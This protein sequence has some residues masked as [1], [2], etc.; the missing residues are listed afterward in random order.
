MLGSIAEKSLR[1]RLMTLVFFAMLAVGGFYYIPLI[2]IDAVPD[3]TSVQVVV[4]TKTGALDPEQIEKTVTY[5][6]E[7]EMSGI[8]GVDEVRSLSKYGLS[9]VV[10]IFKD[11]TNIY[12]ARQQVSERL[13]AV[14]ESLPQGAGPELAPITT[15]L[16]EVLMYVVLP[17]PGS[18]LASAEEKER[19]LYLRTIQDFV[20]RPYLRAHVPNVAEVDSNGGF[21]KEIHIEVD[22][23][24][25]EERGLSIEDLV[26]KLE[27]LGESFGGGYIQHEGKQ[28][29]VRA[30]GSL[31]DLDQIRRITVKLDVRGKPIRLGEVTQIRQDHAQRLGAATYDGNEAVLGTVLMLSGANSRQVAL[32]AE[33][34]LKEMEL[35]P[36]VAIKILYSRRFLVEAVIKTVAKNLAEGA[37]LVVIVLLLLLG[38]LRAALI[39][40]LAIPLSMLVAAMGMK[41]LGISAN[42]MSLGAIDFGLL[43]DASVVIIENV[44]R[45]LR[46]KQGNLSLA[47]KSHLVIESCREVVIPVTLGLLLIMAAYVP[48]LALE[49]IEGKIFRPMAQTVLMAL[50]ASLLVALFLMPVLAYLFLR[51]GQGGAGETRLFAFIQKYYEPLL[52]WSFH[53]PTTVLGPVIVIAF[54]TLFAYKRLGAD[55]MPAL[56]EGDMVINLTREAS[57]GPDESVRIQ[58]E[59]DKVIASFGEVKHVFSRL[60][61]AESATDPMGI[62]LSDTF[63]ILEKVGNKWPVSSG[64]K[65]KTKEELFEAIRKT[66][67]EKTPGQEIMQSQPIEMRLNEI[68]EGSR[69][70]VSVRIYGKDLE[71]LMDLLDKSKALLQEIPGASEV[72]LDALTALRRS[73]VI[74]VRLDYEKIARLGVDIQWVN[75]LLETAMGGREVG[76]FYEQ[77][78]RFPIVVRLTE[79]L[80]DNPKELANL[81]VGLPEKGTAPLSALATLENKDQVTTIAHEGGQR[82]AAVSVN[83][84]AS[85]TEGFVREAKRVLS[86]ELSLP[87]GYRLSWGGQFKNLERAQAKLKVI[88]PLTLLAIFLALL[89][90]FERNWRQALIVYLG[91]PFAVTGGVFS[92]YLRDI[93]LSVSAAVGFIALSGIAILNAMV[94]VTFFN[95]LRKQGFSLRESVL[96]GSLIRLRPV[97][98]TALVASLGFLPMALNT[99]IG[100]EVQRPLAT[101]VIGGLMTSTIL[102]LLILPVLYGRFGSKH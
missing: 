96:K 100:A 14:R 4:N 42:L 74:N 25:L 65:R 38:S 54:L 37:A 22:P 30:Y 89:W 29:I 86:K 21:K 49:G 35:P 58:K 87:Q 98:M 64:G 32:R 70:D 12:W 2:P 82:Y 91:I 9:Q 66:L 77:Q 73:P 40:S 69:A 50:G 61:T 24:R 41:Y 52:R 53:H 15:G 11:G 71:V 95:Q 27:T 90:N 5:P 6:I 13:G 28:I 68:M 88:V 18:K 36:D 17:K 78:W 55:F 80:R 19:L 84:A 3:I 20:I 7:T 43:V 8:A 72:E 31:E 81:P 60:G 51:E 33:K 76:S 48:I 62:H 44:F 99:G 47:E 94:L 97:L 79:N 23:R 16:G 101:V 57:I 63:L 34:T 56:N 102:T 39:V 67:E 92:L 26:Q 45:R 10:V 59:S 1:H 75:K 83:L 85:D 93:P 46:E